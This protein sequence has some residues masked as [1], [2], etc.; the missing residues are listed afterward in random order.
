MILVELHSLFQKRN[1]LI[2]PLLLPSD[3]SEE[4]IGRGIARLDREQAPEDGLGPAELLSIYVV[5]SQGEIRLKDRGALGDH[6]LQLCGGLV[7]PALRL[8]D[9]G[10]G[11]A[12]GSA[13]RI[14]L[15]GVP[16]CPQRLR[17]ESPS[18][19][20]SGRDVPERR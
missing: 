10:Q 15:D 20:A 19:R 7:K 1:R 2:P 3:A 17:R 18:W 14:E 16:S 13:S 11:K 8:V 12:G 9:L 4:K 6:R 5:A